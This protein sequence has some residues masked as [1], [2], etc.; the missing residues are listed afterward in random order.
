MKVGFIGSGAICQYVMDQ[1]NLQN[2]YSFRVNSLFV[3]NM[4][5]Y[6]HLKE[7]YGVNLYDDFTQFL[8][9]DIDVVVE[10]ATIEA[11]LEYVPQALKSHN[12]V[13][14]SIG[15]FNDAHF[16]DK[17]RRMTEKN[18]TKLFVP[19]GAIG[20][21][22]FIQ[23]VATTNTVEDITLETRKPAHT[24][25]DEP[26]AKPTVIFNGSASEV[27]D[28]YPRNMNVAIALG[29]AGIGF[30]KTHVRLI[31]DP[32]VDKNV[33]MITAKGAFGEATIEIKNDP[34]P[35]NPKSSYLAA[36]S[37]VG[38]LEKMNRAIVIS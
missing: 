9:S 34:L 30:S 32:T 27:I 33:H 11:V 2:D 8:N 3:R 22:D 14:I 28:K 10:A 29:L 23:H 16:Y 26:V 31:A 38:M 15:A 20:G 1:A 17:V 4:T 24:L 25:V 6:E 21:L 36:I 13:V 7:R 18:K 5:K 19:S 35:D 12:V 37:I